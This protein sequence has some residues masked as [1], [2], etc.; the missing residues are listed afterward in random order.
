MELPGT[1]YERRDVEIAYPHLPHSLYSGFEATLNMT[2]FEIGEH[3]LKVIATD[4]MGI[5]HELQIPLILM[6]N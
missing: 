5:Q 2:D 4:T 3:Q 1:N 6:P